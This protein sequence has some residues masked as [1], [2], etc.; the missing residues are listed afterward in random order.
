MKTA[1]LDCFSGISGDMFLGALLDAGLDPKIL[2][3]LVK[4]LGLQKVGLKITRESRCGLEG[5]R[6]QVQ[7]PTHSPER[8]L[9]D[10]LKRIEK[11]KLSSNVQEN[12][13]AI[14]QHLAKVEAKIHGTTPEKIH[15]HEIGAEDSL[16]DI[17]GACLAI[18]MMGLRTIYA[19]SIPLGGGFHKTAHGELPMPGPA[20]L[21]LLKGVPVTRDSRK[22]ELV[23]PTGAVL[24]KHFCKG[25]GA[26]PEMRIE[27]IGYGVGSKDFA[28]YPNLLRVL[29]GEK[30]S[31]SEDTEVDHIIL[32][33]TNIDD[34]N[35]QFFSYVSELL[36]EAG[37]LDVYLSPIQM[38]NSRSGIK[39]SALV[40]P[41]DEKKMCD[42]FFKETPTLGIRRSQ[43]G[44]IKLQRKIKIF[45]SSIG[46]VSIKLG[47]QAGRLVSLAPEYKDLKA[48]AKKTGRPIREI[49]I[50]V[51]SEARKKILS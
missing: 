31:I 8:K 5:T 29:I 21:E 32:L 16:V 46:P 11:A 35:P 17:V 38:K 48:L 20:A 51:I 14:F 22:G 15:F 28:P 42:I 2:K 23:T 40:K 36:F 43:I 12:A 9:K 30:T 6:L 47:F 49:H 25:Y 7:I 3:D 10:I 26:L 24:L 37:A 44:R 45:Q 4:R 27:T 50:Q 13:Q 34:M 41:S 18:D 1:Y 33:E 39:L 19:S